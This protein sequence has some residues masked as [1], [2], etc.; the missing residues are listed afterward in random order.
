MSLV[1]QALEGSKTIRGARGEPTKQKVKRFSSEGYRRLVAA[2]PCAYCKTPDRS[3]AAHINSLE[4]GK[5]RGIKPPDWAIFPLCAD[6][7]LR[8]GCHWRYDSNLP[9]AS[10]WRDVFDPEEAISKTI[11][12]LLLAGQIELGIK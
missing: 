10:P 1:S 5:G 12:Y 8:P 4:Y 3:Q 9:L 2:L 11:L 6:A 7:P